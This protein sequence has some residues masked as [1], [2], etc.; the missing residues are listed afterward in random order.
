[1]KETGLKGVRRKQ[2]EREREKRATICLFYIFSYIPL[3]DVKEKIVLNS[4]LS[5]SEY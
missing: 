3:F 5:V 1:M 4:L 2:K